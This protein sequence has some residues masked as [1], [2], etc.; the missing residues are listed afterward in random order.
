MELG[1]E[2]YRSETRPYLNEKVMR[3]HVFFVLSEFSVP[4]WW[5]QIA[6]KFSILFFGGSEVKRKARRIAETFKDAIKDVVHVEWF[7][8]SHIQVMELVFCELALFNS[9]TQRSEILLQ[10]IFCWKESEN[11][12][13]LLRANRWIRAHITFVVLFLKARYY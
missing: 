4:I 7:N 1:N 12:W 8:S 6:P 3:S 13:A 2:T 9:L 11:V 10:K 5:Q